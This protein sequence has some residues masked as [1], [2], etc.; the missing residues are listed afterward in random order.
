M[1]P[2]TKLREKTSI[3]FIETFAIIFV[4]LYI[5]H[6]HILLWSK[7][8]KSYSQWFIITVMKLYRYFSF[9]QTKGSD[10]QALLENYNE[11]RYFIDLVCFLTIILEISLFYSCFC[12]QKFCKAFIANSL[13]IKSIGGIRSV[14]CL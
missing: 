11:W 6:L 2:T 1:Y 10:S 9:W 13:F 7:H 12:V 5:H 3:E 4:T 8:V 14:T